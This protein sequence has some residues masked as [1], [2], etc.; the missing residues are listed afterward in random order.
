MLLPQQPPECWDIRPGSP[1]PG[2]H[3]DGNTK[4]SRVGVS[5]GPGC[6]AKALGGVPAP[7]PSAGAGAPL[8]PRPPE[9]HRNPLLSLHYNLFI[10]HKNPPHPTP[11]RQASRHCGRC[12]H[13]VRD[14]NH[15]ACWQAAGTFALGQLLRWILG[16][17]V[18]GPHHQAAAP[19]SCLSIPRAPAPRVDWGFSP[20]ALVLDSA[21]LW[22][23][24]I[25]K[26]WR[27]CRGGGDGG[28]R[29]ALPE[30]PWAGAG[31]QPPGAHRIVTAANVPH[32]TGLG[33]RQP[34][35]QEKPQGSRDHPWTES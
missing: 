7:P 33:S 16:L 13:C 31:P 24:V 3:L 20:V 21:C 2:P 14:L 27:A 22:V 29:G 11:A 15:A 10:S 12:P 34:P 17:S 6:G 25:S 4:R 35:G 19:V 9:T 18:Y 26:G 8:P 28:G 23:L 32:I 1:R 30:F 5:P